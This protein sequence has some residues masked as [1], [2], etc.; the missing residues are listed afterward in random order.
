MARVNWFLVVAIL[1]SLSVFFYTVK[2]VVVFKWQT[3]KAVDP[4]P[5]TIFYQLSPE[6]KGIKWGDPELKTVLG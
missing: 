1:C 5:R 4:E 2:E 6:F 3:R